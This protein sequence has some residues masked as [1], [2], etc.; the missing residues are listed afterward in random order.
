MVPGV[1]KV[2]QSIQSVTSMMGSAC[3]TGRYFLERKK[4]FI[5]Y[6]GPTILALKNLNS[7]LISFPYYW[8]MSR[9]E[10]ESVLS[11]IE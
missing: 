8:N 7:I 10:G 6:E 3:H 1:K 5:T 2:R 4:C 11:P 9:G